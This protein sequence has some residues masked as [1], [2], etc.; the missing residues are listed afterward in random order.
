M[1][2]EEDGTLLNRERFNEAQRAYDSGDY[3]AALEGYYVCLK[4]DAGD[5]AAGEAGL[6]YHNLGNSL[7]KLRNVADAATAYSKA[8]LD[9]DYE[10]ATSV[11]SNYGMALLSLKRDDEAIEQ[12]TEVLKDSTYPTPYKAYNG[13]GKAYMQ[14]GNLAAAGTAYRNAAVDEANPSPVKALL[15][16]GV[17]FMGLGRPQDALET[18]RT[19]FDFDPDDETVN[20][21]H[22]NM[23]QAYVALMDYPAAV[24]AF[25]KALEDG[26]YELSA[27][28]RD[29]YAKALDPDGDSAAAEALSALG[30]ADDVTRVIPQDYTSGDLNI[31]NRDA[32]RG[33]DEVGAGI[34]SADDTGF[35]SATD[36]EIMGL[37]AARRGESRKRHRGLKLLLALI[38]LLIL[39][40]GAAGALFFLGYGFP[41]QEMVITDMFE[42]R[43]S[44]EDATRYWVH[45]DDETQINEIKGIM[46][47]VRPTSEVRI[48]YLSRNTTSS[49]AIVTATVQNGGGQIR[50]RV[51]LARD[52]ISWKVNSLTF[53]FPSAADTGQAQDLS[54]IPASA[55]S[56]QGATGT[57]ASSSSLSGSATREGTAGSSG[58]GNV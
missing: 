24:E 18:Y 20:K 34:P 2:L 41:T 22:S 4:Q 43:R 38:I 39:M 15:N 9:T 6:L 21:N 52:M 27:A 16:L 13:L 25:E 55:A 50:Y 33:D 3:S 31:A 54:A 12:F 8:L 30:V 32:I 28:A 35:F 48:D 19:V 58:V 53:A 29:D 49:E 42:A 11:R 56:T 44:G 51:K 17:C 26:T 23:G 7:M 36:E 46:N 1:D 14:A 37:T 47:A 40:I 57:A 45:S 10:A 5:L